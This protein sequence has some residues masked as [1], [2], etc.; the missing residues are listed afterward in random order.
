MSAFARH[1]FMGQP[2]SMDAC[3]RVVGP[4][5]R[6]GVFK[7]SLQDGGSLD[8]TVALESF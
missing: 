5:D 1:G 4:D 8:Y 7:S 2:R 3:G 6:L